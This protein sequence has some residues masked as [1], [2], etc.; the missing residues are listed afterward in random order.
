[1]VLHLAQNR[2]LADARARYSAAWLLHQSAT[3]GR[4]ASMRQNRTPVQVTF[5]GR[6]VS[7]FETM[8]VVRLPGEG[9]TL[10]ENLRSKQTSP[11]EGIAHRPSTVRVFASVGA[12]PAGRE[13][14]IHEPFPPLTNYH[15]P[16][17]VF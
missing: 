4:L 17:T 15:S 3:I 1:M 14:K 11:A 16:I 7:V 10:F 13:H 12:R 5:A 9:R 6:S 2:D 8:K